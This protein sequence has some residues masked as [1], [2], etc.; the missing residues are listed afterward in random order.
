MEI[1]EITETIKP[2]TSK[3]GMII[4]W[5]AETISKYISIETS[6]IRTIIL[7]LISIWIAGIFSP[8]NRFTR[9]TFWFLVALVYFALS[10]LGI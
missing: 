5:L 1:T 10:W 3:V 2:I 8:S 6:T 9:I 4:T 7:I